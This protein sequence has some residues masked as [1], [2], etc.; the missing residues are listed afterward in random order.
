MRSVFGLCFQDLTRSKSFD[1]NLSKNKGGQATGAQGIKNIIHLWGQQ[2]ILWGILFPDSLISTK[3]LEI[4]S[5]I[6]KPCSMETII[7]LSTNLHYSVERL[8]T[9]STVSKA[10]QKGALISEFFTPGTLQ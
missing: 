2:C 1:E 4:Y 8:Q 10:I 7:K 6:V 5:R 3:S 9:I